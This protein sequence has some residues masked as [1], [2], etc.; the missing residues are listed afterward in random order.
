MD[1]IGTSL[2]AEESTGGGSRLTDTPEKILL[3]SKIENR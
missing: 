1:P 3:A 2:I